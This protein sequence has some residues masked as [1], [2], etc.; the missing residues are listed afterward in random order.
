[1]DHN[2]LIL[3]FSSDKHDCWKGY[4]CPIN[5]IFLADKKNWFLWI[6]CSL[7]LAQW[8]IWIINFDHGWSYFP[9]MIT[10]EDHMR[11]SHERTNSRLVFRKSVWRN[12]KFVVVQ[13]QLH[14]FQKKCGM[15][16]MWPP[17]VKESSI[18]KTLMIHLIMH[19]RDKPRIDEGVNLGRFVD[20]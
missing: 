11:K 6:I 9:L 8:M 14:Q 12:Y 7:G 13:V 20:D 19:R 10:W 17:T 5:L 15:H 1:M 18:G 2:I 3:H 4:W 16:K